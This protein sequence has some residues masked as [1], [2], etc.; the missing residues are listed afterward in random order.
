ME[1]FF[2]QTYSPTTSLLCLI[3]CL[4][5]FLLSMHRFTDNNTVKT[6]IDSTA[7]LSKIL[8]TTEVATMD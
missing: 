5:L 2:T 3:L 4:T 8:T 1:L 6:K 7:K